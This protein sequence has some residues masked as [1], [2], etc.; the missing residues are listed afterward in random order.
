MESKNIINLSLKKEDFNK[1]V[2]M[3]K[4][5]LKRFMFEDKNKQEVLSELKGISSILNEVI[6][7]IKEKEEK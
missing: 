2:Q 7:E 3:I 5:F 4:V 6:E 1:S